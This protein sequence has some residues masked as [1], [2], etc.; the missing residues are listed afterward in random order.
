MGVVS[1]AYVKGSKRDTYDVLVL[2]GGFSFMQMIENSWESFN[3]IYDLLKMST[4][5]GNVVVEYVIKLDTIRNTL[6]DY[7]DYTDNVIDKLS[8]QD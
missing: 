5:D 6:Q 7:M 2:L 3:D 1:L 8:L 4:D